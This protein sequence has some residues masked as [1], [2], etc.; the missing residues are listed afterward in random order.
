MMEVVLANYSVYSSN[1]ELL[2]A[3]LQ[4]P[5]VCDEAILVARSIANQRGESVWLGPEDAEWEELEEI[6]P[7]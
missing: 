7:A 6:E 3:G 2:T 5:S 1:G 4:G